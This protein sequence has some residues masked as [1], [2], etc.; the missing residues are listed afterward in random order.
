MIVFGRRAATPAARRTP[1]ESAP[2]E[3]PGGRDEGCGRDMGAPCRLAPPVSL[4]RGTGSRAPLPRVDTG[5]IPPV[6]GSAG[7]A[8]PGASG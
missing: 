6:V 8:P 3:A 7:F 1:R 5:A 2:V 4:G